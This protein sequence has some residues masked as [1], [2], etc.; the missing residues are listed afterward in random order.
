MLN[1]CVPFKL[2][3]ATGISVT[4]S[5]NNISGFIDTDFYVL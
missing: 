3:I 5:V 1:I 2:K 4:T